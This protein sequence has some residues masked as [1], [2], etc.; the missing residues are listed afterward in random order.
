MSAKDTRHCQKDQDIHI[1]LMPSSEELILPNFDL[2]GIQDERARECV[3]QLHNLVETLMADL[4]ES[5]SENQRLRDELNR[6]KG[7]QGRPSIKP[8]RSGSSGTSGR[9][10]SERERREPKD[11]QKNSKLDKILIDR[12]EILKLDPTSLPQDSEFKGYEP[13]VVQD[14]RISTDNIKFLKEKYYSAAAGKTYLAPLPKSY[15]GEFG[16]GVKSLAIVFA[17]GCNM[18]EPKIA[19]FFANIGILISAGQISNLLI[20]GQEKFHAE[21]DAIV[22]AGLSSSPWQNMDDTSTRVNGQNRHCQVV[23]NPLYTAYFT[24]ER[25][26]RLTVIDVLRNMCARTFRINEEAFGFFRQF[27]L[28][29]RVIEALGNVPRDQNLGEAEFHSWLETHVCSLGPQQRSRIL[30]ASAVAAYH[31][32]VEHPV[33]R[34]LLCDDAPQFKLVTEELGLCWIHD[35][36]HYKK[37][38]PCIAYHRQLLDSYLEQYW[39]FYKQLRAFRGTPT[40]EHAVYLS[41]EFDRLFSSVTGYEALDERIAKTKAKK[42]HLLMVL[43]H[44]EIP[45]HNNDAELAARLRVRKRAVSFGS[46]SEKG[47]QA[48]DTFH[49]LCST[50]K[51]L[52]VSFYRYIHD[53]VS[54]ADQ[55]LPLA[56]LIAQKAL[57]LNLGNSWNSS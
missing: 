24:T 45:L 53:R 7:E 32:E 18:T 41:D 56:E 43:Q 13:V 14:L 11:W 29:A 33:V 22:Q 50:A 9:H 38:E 40:P 19:E 30:E 35:G 2:A 15:A 17:Y 10:S 49:T 52:G 51:K 25:K 36:R 20:G 37:L 21:K 57:Q 44:P 55:M 3:R 28:P 27:A 1:P 48:W 23:C 16:P 26:D 54:K 39:D 42:S 5:R 6:L 4:R 8:N 46:R 12:E 31:A 34:L 47:I